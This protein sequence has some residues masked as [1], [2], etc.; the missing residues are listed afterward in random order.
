MTLAKQGNS[1]L[2]HAGWRP[3]AIV[4]TTFLAAFP[5]PASAQTLPDG[6]ATTL[7]A[8]VL[9]PEALTGAGPASRAGSLTVPTVAE[10]KREKAGVAGAVTVVDT[11][12]YRATTSARTIQDALNY[13][14]GVFAQPKWGEDTRLSIRGSGLSRNF[15]LRGVALYLDGVPISTADGFGDFQEIDPTA[16][17]QID[18]Y[19]GANGQRF[20]AATLGGAI[21][22]VTPSGRDAPALDMRSDVGS[23]GFVRQQ[24]STAGAS[25]IYDYFVTGSWQRQDGFRDHSQGSAW[26]GSGNLGIRLSE[27]VE[28]RFYLNANDVRQHIPGSVTRDVAL[29]SPQTA[30]AGNVS[31]NWQR[32]IETVRIAN[33]TTIRL[34]PGSALEVGIFNV[35]RHLQH[36][37]FQWLDYTYQDYGTFARLSDERQVLGHRNRLNIGVNFHEGTTD[38]DQYVNSG[39]N[40]GALLSSTRNEARN[41]TVHVEN[42]FY[43]LPQVALV[44]GSQFLSARRTLDDRFLSDGDQSG[45]RTFTRW[46]PKAGVLWEAGRDW[47]VFANVAQSAEAPSFGENSYASAAAFDAKLQK[48]TTY[49]VGSRG[50]IG[51]INWD[52]TAYRSNIDNELQCTFAFGVSSFCIVR[53]A[54]RTVHQGLEL[55]FGATAISGLMVQEGTPDRIAVNLA[56]AWNDFRFDGDAVYGDNRLP[57]APEHVV[58][59]QAIYHHPSGVYAGPD[60]EWS[61]QS[62]FVDS[63]NSLS[64]DSYA[65]IGLKAGY[66]TGSGV[67]V[68]AE[69]R[70][71]ADTRYIASTGI[72]NVANAATT[73][74]FEPGSGRAA[75]AGIRYRW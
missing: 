5:A 67:S 18:V 53:N 52:V 29:N 28:T 9:E 61:P 38:A 39:G 24:A 46:S 45:G 2:P 13:G 68:Y 51:D 33:K 70:N 54:E 6:A 48:A 7:P 73:N 59:A 23:F 47:Q 22:F 30:A 71:L 10:N 27:D 16:Y 50:E 14:P 4:F 21:D 55:G 8:L 63:K 15:H 43:V 11:A 19:K 49:E 62:Y 36:P 12:A 1:P 32:N 41:V 58:K 42:T 72:T 26:R 17:R 44:A 64:T 56:Y 35:D 3:L 25:G 60:L 40:K 65:L 37:I 31:G 57:G 34:A 75:Y 74:L 20:G 69:A 66:D